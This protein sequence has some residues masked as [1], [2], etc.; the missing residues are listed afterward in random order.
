MPP[1]FSPLFYPLQGAI[2][3][4]SGLSPSRQ[5]RERALDHFRDACRR[6][7]DSGSAWRMQF[8]CLARTGI[9]TPMKNF[10]SSSGRTVSCICAVPTNRSRLL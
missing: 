9:S 1:P 5:F 4:Y 10:P 8:C 6:I 2:R 7:A 3:R